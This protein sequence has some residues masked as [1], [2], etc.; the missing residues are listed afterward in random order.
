MAL[1]KPAEQNQSAAHVRPDHQ[2]PDRDCQLLREQLHAPQAEVRRWAARDI[3]DCP[4]SSQAL[5]QCLLVEPE[6]SVREIMLTTLVRIGDAPAVEGLVQCLRS[7]EA[8]L[9]SEAIEALKQLPE[10]VAP[11]MRQL[12]TDEA[13][14]VRIFAVNVLESLRHPAV[15]TWLTEVIVRDA[16]VNVCATAVDLLGEVGSRAAL[17][18]LQ[19]LKSRFPQEPYIQFAADLAIKRIQNAKNYHDRAHHQRRRLHQVS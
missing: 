4:Q 18:P 12:L 9:R 5:V 13:S 16:H 8:A 11:I 17:G 1:I 14:D 7:E 15:E 19:Q 3:V 6:Q 10:M 2:R